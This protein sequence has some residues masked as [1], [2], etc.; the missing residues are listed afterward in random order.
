[1]T[2]AAFSPD[3]R[4][5]LP[6]SLQR[7]IGIVG[8]GGIVHYGHLP[9]YRQYGFHVAA[10]AS[11]SAEKVPATADKFGVTRRFTDWREMI[12]LPEV[13]VVDVTYPFDEERLEIV[14]AAAQRGK[15]ILMQKPLAH[16]LANATR[17]VELA[18]RHGVLLA[19]NQNARWCPQYRAA[20]LAIEAGLIGQPSFVSHLMSNNQDGAA[21]FQASW[22]ARQPQFQ[23]LEYAVHH[24]DLVRF[25]L[26]REPVAVKASISRAPHQQSAGE[27]TASIQLRFADGGLANV[28]EYNAAA[29]CVEPTSQFLIDGPDG[30]IR[31]CAMG[32]LEFEVVSRRL[33]AGPCRPALTGAWFPDGFAGTM[34]ELMCAIEQQRQPSISGADNLRT[35]AIVFA[36]YRDALATEG[37]GASDRA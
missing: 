31:G 18:R 11:R 32:P 22:M 20:R 34:G 6:Q 30:R 33:A 21:W 9:A 29:D 13:E 24:L 17:L 15:H 8:A 1:M 23:I 35:L 28:S 25:W 27:M 4:P 5:T 16:T 26:G 36:A 2:T 3:V 10:L 7:G 19:V 12:A 37:T 14:A